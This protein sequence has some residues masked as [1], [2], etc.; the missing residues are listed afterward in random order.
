MDSRASLYEIPFLDTENTTL[1]HF[2]E[3]NLVVF[4]VYFN[5]LV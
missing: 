5:V 4:L 2:H 1:P 3:P